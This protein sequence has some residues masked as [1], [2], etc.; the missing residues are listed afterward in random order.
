MK[1]R[2]IIDV[3]LLTI[4]MSIWFEK[5]LKLHIFKALTYKIFNKEMTVFILNFKI[6]HK[7]SKM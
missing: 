5:R 6:V 3:S 4:E 7:K 2:M 1:K